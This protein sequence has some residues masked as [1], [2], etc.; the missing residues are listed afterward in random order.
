VAKLELVF[1]QCDKEERGASCEWLD[2]KLTTAGLA[3]ASPVKLPYDVPENSLKKD[4]SL[5]ALA[6][7]FAAASDALEAV[8]AKHARPKPSP[9]WLW[10][11]HF[12][13]AATFPVADGKS[14][15]VG[16]SMGD[17]HYAEPYAYIS[18][19]PAPKDAAAGAL[20][21]GGHWHTKDFFGAVATAEELLEQPDPRKALM[22][23][24]DAAFNAGKRWL[25]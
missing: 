2:G 6:R 15:G 21:P 12:D 4:P 16:V 13:L 9:A 18:A 14:I 5:P 19:Y 7:W 3:P 1:F 20:P 10:P 17:H 22:A 11:H 25:S 8:R 23:V 24:I